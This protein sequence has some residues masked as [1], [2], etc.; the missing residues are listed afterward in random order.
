[1][2]KIIPI[3]FALLLAA[4]ATNAPKVS[5]TTEGLTG[6]YEV[7]VATD[8]QERLSLYPD[9]R[10]AYE[11]NELFQGNK[12]GVYIGRW[13][14]RGQSIVLFTKD[15]EGKE[16]EFPLDVRKEKKDYDLV[17]TQDSYAAA[18][19][20]MLIPDTF[21]RTSKTPNHALLRTPPGVT[22]RAGARAAPPAVAAE[23]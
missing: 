15:K 2:K 9:G 23:L 17:Y 3:I 21:H 19:A 18:K 8:T 20:K 10:F 22:S 5:L 4:C 1:V 12:S 7:L 6:L 16:V 11:Y 14:I 13:E